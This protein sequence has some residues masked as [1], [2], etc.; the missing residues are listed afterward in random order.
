MPDGVFVLKN[1]CMCC[2][3]ESPGS[4]LERVLD[5]LLEL[6][7]VEGGSMPFDAILV[8]TSGLADPSPIV[9]ARAPPPARPNS[10]RSCT[11]AV[12]RASRGTVSHVAA[13]RRLLFVP[14]DRDRCGCAARQVLCRHEMG[15]SRYY[16]DAVLA[17]VDA[18]HV[19]RHLQVRGVRIT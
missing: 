10:A 14:L 4:E 19:M 7:G 9:Q 1:G 11:H 8:E 3:G 15:R 5:K 6:A 13:R 17:M 12:R 16:L 18:K 2:S